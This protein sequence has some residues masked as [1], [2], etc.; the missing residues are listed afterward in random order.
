MNVMSCIFKFE[1][2]L[3]CVV[4]YNSDERPVHHHD[5]YHDDRFL[6]MLKHE[7]YDYFHLMGFSFSWQASDYVL[8]VKLTAVEFS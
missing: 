2:H 5:D 6:K 3:K 1:E 4:E 8:F 7:T